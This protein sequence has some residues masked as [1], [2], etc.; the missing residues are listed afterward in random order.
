MDAKRN[1][2]V[3]SRG[4]G[5]VTVLPSK[6]DVVTSRRISTSLRRDID[7]FNR[8]FDAWQIEAQQQRR[9]ALLA[10]PFASPEDFEQALLVFNRRG[11]RSRTQE[12]Y[13][14]QRQSSGPGGGQQCTRCLVSIERHAPF[15]V[16]RAR[17]RWQA[18]EL[19]RVCICA[20]MRQLLGEEESEI[21]R[22]A[23]EALS[24][25]WA[26]LLLREPQ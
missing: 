7:G 9:E 18:D 19:C 13:F 5:A 11:D 20:A 8:L 6:F 10:R 1:P 3:A 24:A 4:G 21:S 23:E 26:P 12:W 16:D 17:S 22:E 14:V 15:Y 2:A 25:A